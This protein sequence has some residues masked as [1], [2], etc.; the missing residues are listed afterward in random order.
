MNPYIH[1]FSIHIPSYGLLALVSLMVLSAYGIIKAKQNDLSIYDFLILESIAL[2]GALIGS[3]LLFVTLNF[4]KI[5]LALSSNLITVNDL[6]TSGFIFYGGLIGALLFLYLF[7]KKFLKVDLKRYLNI[8]IPIIPLCHG[9]ARIGCYLSGCC[10]GIAYDGIGSVVFPENSLAP[11]GIHLFPVQLLE[12]FL[13]FVLSICL[14]IFEKRKSNHLLTSYLVFYGIMRFFLEF[15][16]GDKLEKVYLFS[17]SESQIISLMIILFPV[18][19]LL[20]GRKNGK[21]KSYS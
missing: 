5:Q 6:L 15:L 8:V 19:Y 9:I 4:N 11:S 2:L 13:L 18:L 10:Y 1:L 3:K 14:F 12:A 7:N 21:G 17:L 16:R 20:L